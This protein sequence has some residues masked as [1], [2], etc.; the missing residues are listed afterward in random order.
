MVPYKYTSRGIQ[1]WD[2]SVCLYLNLK[3]GN[4]DHLATTTI[5]TQVIYSTKRHKI[6]LF[7]FLSILECIGLTHLIKL[8]PQTKPLNLEQPTSPRNS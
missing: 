7:V 4:S 8:L 5:Y 1:T 3:H 6:N 2:L